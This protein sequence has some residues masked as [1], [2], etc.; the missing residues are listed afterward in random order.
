MATFSTPKLDGAV[1]RFKGYFTGYTELYRFGQFHVTNM[2]IS[3]LVQAAQAALGPNPLAPSFLS[4]FRVALSAVPFVDMTGIN[5]AL[6]GLAA[7]GINVSGIRTL[8]GT[9]AADAINAQAD[10]TTVWSTPTI[11]PIP[12][13]T[14]ATV[15]KLNAAYNLEKGKCFD[16]CRSFARK[17]LKASGGPTALP[18]TAKISQGIIANA[19]VGPVAGLPNLQNIT[20]GNPAGIAPVIS[21][22]KAAIDAKGAVQCGVLSGVKHDMSAF[23]SP[24]HYVLV[25]AYD[26]IGSDDA[27]LFWDPDAAVTNIGTTSWGNGFG[28]LFAGGGRFSTASSA[29]DLNAVS[30]TGDHTADP[31]RHRY[32][33]YYVQSLP[34]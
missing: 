28:V 5:T 22:I 14:P 3:D 16:T 15:G 24:E 4:V 10:Y 33:V 31:D 23:P 29:G 18:T 2:C 8:L 32:Q 7:A 6:M 27:F 12:V 25:F 13:R 9:T 1:T 20:Y 11:L 34:L 21:T 17:L 30:S 19:S 26:S